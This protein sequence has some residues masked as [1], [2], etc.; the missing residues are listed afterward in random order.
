MRASGERARRD[1]LKG[2]AAGAG[3]AAAGIV[4]TRPAYAAD[5]DSPQG[6]PHRPES[7]TARMG[8]TSV[9][10]SVS[11]HGT[12]HWSARRDG[13][14]VIGTSA[15]GVRLGD[16]TVLGSD[17]RVTG[18]RHRTHRST[19]TP[20]YGR[21]ATVTDHYQEHRW[22][23][24]D[25]ATGIRFGVQVR[26]YRTGV[27]LRYLLL[28]TEAASTATITDELTTFVFP[29][30]T[31][32]YSARDENAYEPVAPGSIPVTGTATTDNG[33][34][35]D[36]PLT[37][38]L[39]D[40]LIAC[41]CESSRV[42]YPR[43]MLGSVDGEPNTL[44]AF[45]M[46]HTARGTGPVETASTVTTPFATPWRAVVIGAGHAEL[47]DN[48]ELVLNLAPPNALPDPSWIKPGK[49][50]RCELTTAAGLAGVD[51]AVARGLE[52]IE[53][54]AGWYGPEFTTP[55]ATKPIAAIDLPSVISY[56]TSQGIGVFL[57]VNRLA[58]T[59]A[60]SLFGLYKSWGV[61]GIKLGFINDGTQ[62]MT[63]QIIDWAKT[64]AKY[65]LLIDMHDDVRPFGYE[66]TLPNWISLEGVR[67]NEQFPTATHNVTLPFA[68]NIG[69]PMDY[70]ICYGQSRDK[71]TNAHQMAMAAVYYQPLNFLFWYDKPSKYANP[72]NWPGLPWFNAVP[73][74]WD[75]SRTLAGSIGEYVAV[76]RRSGSVW[77]L[78]AMTDE[79][80]RTLTLP[81]SFLGRG[82]YTA[83][84]YADGTPGASPYQTPVVVGTRSVTRADSLDVAMAPAGGQAVV[85]RPI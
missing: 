52:Y 70:T 82:T 35:T 77:Y 64:A 1:V 31:T 11:T 39:P 50:F 53:Y 3:L 67:G 43:L 49:V 69:G 62:S 24:K 36:L 37:A 12:L 73:T 15:L 34:L 13:R 20:V 45:L 14:T 57:Y 60:D 79:S 25:R 27:A 55:D 74:T 16:G 10:L 33:P 48:A 5:A 84:V 72:A 75:E 18:R 19:W 4:T 7:V 80:S 78:G 6:R 28:D 2:A 17:V 30:G 26:A 38:T 23:L 40:G 29:D 46:E 83:T 41:V 71:T 59:D 21:N 68:R 9:T 61:Q 66:R 54:D 44:S 51:F 63:N 42:D 8:G 58:L 32:V 76:A 56:A 65:Q 85:L 47:V 81:L 22:D